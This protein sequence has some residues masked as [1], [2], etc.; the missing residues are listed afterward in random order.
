MSVDIFIRTYQSDFIWLE[1]L[2]KSIKKYAVGFRNVIIVSDNDGTLVP[3]IYLDILP[4]TV[5]YKDVQDLPSSLNCRHG[6]VWQQILCL[7]W[8]EDT[9][10]D[11]VLV[12]D[13]DSMLTRTTTPDDFKDPS[14]GKFRWFYRKWEQ[15]DAA[16]MWKDPVGKALKY[17][18]DYEAMC[19]PGFILE[20]E[21]TLK[22]IDYLRLLHEAKD[23]T[24]VFFR[25]KAE[26]FSEFN[27]YGS[28]VY[29]FDTTVYSKTF[30]YDIDTSNL[31]NNSIYV[32]W[33]YGGLSKD[34]KQKRLA[35]L[36]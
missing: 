35:I 12:L 21:T 9:D 18:P 29:R 31:I 27:T 1:Y 25:Y 11:A 8:T 17:T 23:L 14:N 22:L 4:C 19:C 3:Q 5:K 16:I 6:Y 36:A 34:D 13:S 7:R 30:I 15:A 24:D 20:R 2:L 28:Y 26:H 10:A 33:S 32:S